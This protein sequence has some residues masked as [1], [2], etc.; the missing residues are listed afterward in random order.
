MFYPDRLA[1]ASLVGTRSGQVPKPCT[2]HP[3]PCTLHPEPCYAMRHCC[4]VSLC[5]CPQAC[6]GAT[7]SFVKS[8]LKHF[9]SVTVHLND[10][11]YATKG[12]QTLNL[13][14]GSNA[15]L[16]LEIPFDWSSELESS[17]DAGTTFVGLLA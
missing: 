17:S 1:T 10:F 5:E 12:I 2:L 6:S 3:A 11:W 14:N 7:A 13:N 9:T 16:N 8:A 15:A 4:I